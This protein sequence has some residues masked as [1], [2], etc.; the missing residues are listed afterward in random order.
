MNIIHCDIKLE[1]TLLQSSSDPSS[2]PIVKLCD[3][4]LAHMIEEQHGN[5]AYMEKMSG[6]LNYKAPEVT[7]NC[8]VGPEIDMWSFG[9]MLYIMSVGYPPSQLKNYKYGSGEIPFWERDWRKKSK[10]LRDLIKACL[11]YNPSKRISSI[12]ALNHPYFSIN[13]HDP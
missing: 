7:D 13:L 9:L 5:R 1:N 2:Y 3:F 12:D 11:Q 6:T 4:G 8:Y 10:E